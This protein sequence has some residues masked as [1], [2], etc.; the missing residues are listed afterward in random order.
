M[1]LPRPGVPLLHLTRAC[2][3]ERRIHLSFL[4]LNSFVFSLILLPSVSPPSSLLF[5]LLPLLLLLLPLAS[6]PPI[7]PSLPPFPYFSLPCPFLFLYIY[8]HIPIHEPT[9]IHGGALKK[10]VG[11]P[12]EEYQGLKNMR[13]S[14]PKCPPTH[15]VFTDHAMPPSDQQRASSDA[16]GIPAQITSRL[17]CLGLG[18]DDGF[19]FTKREKPPELKSLPNYPAC[20]NLTCPVSQKAV[21]DNVVL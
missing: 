15:P 2:Q 1:A 6:L 4:R 11:A 16:P 21:N 13:S 3:G 17:R 8:T 18:G 7:S 9:H 20:V 5:P 10:I 12:E 19:F 14:R